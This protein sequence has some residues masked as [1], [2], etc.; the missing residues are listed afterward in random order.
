MESVNNNLICHVSVG[1]V[2]QSG[3]LLLDGKWLALLL[4]WDL[5]H[6]EV[7]FRVFDGNSVV[8]DLSS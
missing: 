7:L 5:P 2:L 4:H 3:Q 8:R 6:V 1:V